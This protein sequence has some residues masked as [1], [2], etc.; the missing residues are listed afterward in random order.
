MA[1]SGVVGRLIVTLWLAGWFGLSG[2]GSG[3]GT[4]QTGTGT[5]Q[6]LSQQ[7]AQAF[8]TW[9]ACC[10]AG[11][12]APADGG[13]TSDAG[14]PCAAA[15]TDAG[16]PAD[17]LARAEL[18]AEQQLALLA[19]AYSEGLVTID[20]AV[21]KACANAYQARTCG[22]AAEL[23]VDEALAGTACAGVFTGYIPLGE[24]CDMTAECVAGAYCLAQGTGKPIMSVAGAGTLGV[25]F[26]YQAAGSTCNTTADCAPPLT[27]S[28][29]TFV[30]Q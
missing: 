3:S 8:C 17:C 11:G 19:T 29:T 15:T 24:R 25:C 27:C 30:C 22:G 28:P 1:T 12:A 18:A 6:T 13:Q 16:A 2:C 21:S 7:L 4:P 23:N 9:Q 10:A 20:R 5:S 26:P 14:A